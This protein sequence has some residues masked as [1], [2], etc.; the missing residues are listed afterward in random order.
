MQTKARAHQLHTD[1]RS[2][3]LDG[4][5]M[6]EFLSQI[7]NIV[8]ELAGVGNP[9]PHDE[10]VDAI[11]EGL[12]QDYA[13]V[14]SVIE[15]KFETPPVSEV[16]A[17]LFTHELEP[18]DFVNTHLPPLSITLKG[19]CFL[20]QMILVLAIT[21]VVYMATMVEVVATTVV[22]MAAVMEGAVEDALRTS[23]AKFA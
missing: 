23:N 12:P 4:K 11:L 2:T 16:E 18:T 15:S 9:V 14:I 1:L 19:M 3:T 6:R 10:H 8:H 7:K 22:V 5:T 21:L 17:L 13:L 20:T